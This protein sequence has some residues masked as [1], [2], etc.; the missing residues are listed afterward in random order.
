MEFTSLYFAVFAIAS[1]FIYY[2]LGRTSRIVLLNLLSLGFVA[3]L[4]LNL[5]YYI[6][7]YT[8]INYSIGLFIG[9]TESKKQILW[10]GIGLNLLQLILL[11]YVDF[12]ITPLFKL[13][14]SGINPGRISEIIVPIGISYFTFQGIGYLVNIK[15]GWEK[16]ERNI[17]DFLLYIIF[18]PKFLS[19][20]IERSNH[21][22]PQLKNKISFDKSNMT[23]GFRLIL[24]GLFKKLVIANQLS[25]FVT[26][27]YTN[28]ATIP[29]ELVWLL[30]LVQPLYLYFDFSG[31]TDI[32][33][34][35]ARLYGIKLIPNFNSPYLAEN[36]T[37]FWRRW[38]ISLSSWFNDYIFKQL[39]FRLR[40]WKNKASLAALFVTWTL[41]G[42]WHGAG[43]NFMIL[44]FIFAIAMIY[45]FFT[46]KQRYQ[47][48]SKI[49]GL[50]RVWLGRFFT[51]LFYGTALIFFFSPDLTSTVSLF[52]NLGNLDGT[53]DLGISMIPMLFGVVVSIFF[54]GYEVLQNDYEK[55]FANLMRI[56]NNYRF[57]RLVVYY[58]LAV[59]VISEMGNKGSFVY[60][61]F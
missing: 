18:Y 48:F 51:Y 49:P 45:E 61:M 46:R 52:S 38:H 14:D 40:R 42:I 50:P 56:W 22:L 2:L 43:W 10:I 37:N 54:I 6:L 17:L 29:G 11:K 39:M 20:P 47:L 58:I 8:L 5:L 15:M 33:I 19:G 44:G 59:A 31:Y 41:F 1:V 57:L 53:A 28:S 55:F 13:F 30:I 12:T 35:Y 23:V 27:V 3:S 21:F 34:G 60:E 16:P 36:L 4:N 7:G 25:S 26:A 9:K 32:A 24:F